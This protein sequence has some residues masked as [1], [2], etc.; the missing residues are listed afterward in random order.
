MNKKS[1]SC[2][3]NLNQQKNF[4]QRSKSF[5]S[6]TTL[7][8]NFFQ[9]ASTSDVSSNTTTNSST[10]DTSTSSNTCS[11]KVKKKLTRKANFACIPKHDYA[12]LFDAVFLNNSIRMRENSQTSTK[13][14]INAI[15]ER[16]FN[17]QKGSRSVSKHYLCP[18]FTHNN[19]TPCFISERFSALK[20]HLLT[21][22]DSYYYCYGCETKIYS[23]NK[24]LVHFGT[25]CNYLPNRE[26]D[27]IEYLIIDLNEESI[28]NFKLNNPLM[29]QV[30]SKDEFHMASLA[31]KKSHGF[32]LPYNADG[33]IDTS[34][35]MDYVTRAVVNGNERKNSK[36]KKTKVSGSETSYAFLTNKGMMYQSKKTVGL[37]RVNKPLLTQNV[38]SLNSTIFSKYSNSLLRPSMKICNLGVNTLPLKYPPAIV[39]NSRVKIEI[40]SSN[41]T[42]NTSNTKKQYF[43]Q[44]NSSLPFPAYQL[45]KNSCFTEEMLKNQFYAKNAFLSEISKTPI[46]GQIAS[47]SSANNFLISWQSNN[48]NQKTQN[49]KFSRL[50]S[51]VDTSRLDILVDACYKAKALEE[52]K[53]QKQ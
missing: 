30:L 31:S 26:K 18:H 40:P 34:N 21:H 15:N 43:Y 22:K 45:P 33:T 2:V 9:F 24:A 42:F 41:S 25:V 47:L 3:T 48:L 51:E 6:S 52:Q 19:T 29:H 50:N 38:S 28:S 32:P 1:K 37:A 49:A 10:S 17:G 20:E 8:D 27:I 44:N 16:F 14:A 35:L 7:D 5:S 53:Q 46:P 13:I 11:G 23:K 12:Y 36:K 4:D 39:E